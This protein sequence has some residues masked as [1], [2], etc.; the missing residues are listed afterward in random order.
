[1]NEIGGAERSS[2]ATRSMRRRNSLVVSGRPLPGA[3]KHDL[4]YRS[5]VLAYRTLAGWFADHGW[6]GDLQFIPSQTNDITTRSD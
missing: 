5:L 4:S 6:L 1:M 3:L 2:E